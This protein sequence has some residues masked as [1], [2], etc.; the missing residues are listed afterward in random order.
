M[1]LLTTTEVAERL[2]VHVTRVHQLIKEERL[3]AQRLGRDWFLE[4]NDLTL[5][6]DRKPGRPKKP[7]EAEAIEASRKSAPAKTAIRKPQPAY[8][9]IAKA[10][11]K[12][13]AK[14]TE[15]RD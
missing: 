13:S 2:G 14:K 9:P 5:V 6:A 4:A 1:G 12:R 8:P 10:A 11:K 7:D 15:R 3:P